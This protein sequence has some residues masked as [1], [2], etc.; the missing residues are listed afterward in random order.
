MSPVPPKYWLPISLVAVFLIVATVGGLLAKKLVFKEASG[1]SPSDNQIGRRAPDGNAEAELRPTSTSIPELWIIGSD[2]RAL[3]VSRLDPG[4]GIADNFAWSPGGSL[5]AFESYDLGG[6]SPLTTSRAWV[7]RQD[8]SGL[9]QISL[10]SPNERFSTIL[11]G[12]LDDN[13]LK[14]RATILS[15]PDDVYYTFSYGSQNIQPLS[16]YKAH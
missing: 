14:I 16:D 11:D 12:W 8:G 3:K 15:A 7:V 9:V 10:P 4:M 5:L 1:T 13:T 6:H 2:G